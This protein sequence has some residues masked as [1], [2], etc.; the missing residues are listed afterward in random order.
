M[1]ELALNPLYSH[2]SELRK[3]VIMDTTS[4]TLNTDRTALLNDK[5]SN[6]FLKFLAIVFAIMLLFG[7]LLGGIGLLVEVISP[8]PDAPALRVTYA[9]MFVICA[10]LLGID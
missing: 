2:G 9:V 4:A 10:E 3:G 5:D 7:A 6:P 8:L 1:C